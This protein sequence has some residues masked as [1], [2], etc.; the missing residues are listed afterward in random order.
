MEMASGR[1]G[2][3]V[4]LHHTRHAKALKKYG[5]VHYVSKK[6]R[7]A[8]LYCD[9]DKRDAVMERLAK[10]RFTKRVDLSH[11]KELD[12]RYQKKHKTERRREEDELL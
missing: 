7:Y 2:L 4:W 5:N 9:A 8:I 6:M 10:Q 3:I 11:L 12:N 1:A